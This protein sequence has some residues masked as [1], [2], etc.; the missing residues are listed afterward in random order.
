MVGETIRYLGIVAFQPATGE[1]EGG[2]ARWCGMDPPLVR[3]LATR[4]RWHRVVLEVM[5]SGVSRM[6]RFPVSDTLAKQQ[7]H[8]RSHHIPGRE[9]AQL[10]HLSEF[11]SLLC[12]HNNPRLTFTSQSEY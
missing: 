2:P 8:P 5:A 11:L 4:C 6:P 9:A 3:N 12:S 10:G 1:A 7:N